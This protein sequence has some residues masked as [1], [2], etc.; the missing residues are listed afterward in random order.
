MHRPHPQIPLKHTQTIHSVCS[1]WDKEYRYG[2]NGKE[3]DKGSEGMGGGCST[4]DYGFRI[5]NPSLGKFL[6]VDPLT[7]SYPWYT[8]YQFA[9]N[10]PINCIDLDGLE[11]YA[12]ILWV[13]KNGGYG[14]RV[15][16]IKEDG[17]LTISY[18]SRPQNTTSP[19]P[20]QTCSECFPMGVQPTDQL[21]VKRV[22]G[23]DGVTSDNIWETQYMANRGNAAMTANRAGSNFGAAGIDNSFDGSLVISRKV[24]VSHS[25]T[26]KQDGTI[27]FSIG[28]ITQ[29][30]TEVNLN[31]FFNDM[32]L[33]YK[34][35]TIIKKEYNSKS[36][37]S[38]SDNS[39]LVI[40]TRTQKQKKS[41]ED[42]FK[43]TGM[44]GS[45]IVVDKNKF[46]GK[47]E[48]FVFYEYNEKG[49]TTTTSTTTVTAH[50]TAT[51]STKSSTKSSKTSKD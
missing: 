13:S 49:G 16:V 7:A 43:V 42:L 31:Y 21:L 26:Q 41:L 14:V 35:L 4:Y 51:G 47:G 1:V 37:N 45:K 22:V 29:H 36:D 27:K 9:G 33:R 39:N 17:P 25:K 19:G 18:Y 40:Y 44:E 12:V 38:K 2:F 20:N 10:K 8:P 23:K 50:I 15:H 48:R 24:N 46:K 32:A 28:K 34:A 11:E 3:I 30:A 5:Y 6:S